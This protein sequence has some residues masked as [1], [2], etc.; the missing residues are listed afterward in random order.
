[1][2]EPLTLAPTIGPRWSGSSCAGVGLTCAE[3]A[4]LQVGDW[5]RS[6][7][8]MSSDNAAWSTCRARLRARGAAPCRSDSQPCFS[9]CT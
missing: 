3:V 4:E 7:E 8:T 5:D 1:M 6:S 2:M 9:H